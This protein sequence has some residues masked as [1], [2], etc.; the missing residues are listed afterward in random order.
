MKLLWL[1]YLVIL[2]ILLSIG[3]HAFTI[4]VTTNVHTLAATSANLEANPVNRY[5]ENFNYLQ[6]ILDPISYALII[7]VYLFLRH[8]WLHTRQSLLKIEL[9]WALYFMVLFIF[10][11]SFNDFINDLAVVIS[12]IL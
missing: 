9:H 1:D 11:A 10:I 8:K 2:S 7:S 12:V 5:L 6:F 4:I 3:A